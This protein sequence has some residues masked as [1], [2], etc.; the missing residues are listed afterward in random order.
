MA[1]SYRKSIRSKK[2]RK[3]RHQRKKTEKRIKKRGL[4]LKKNKRLRRSQILQYGGKSGLEEFEEL[5]FDKKEPVPDIPENQVIDTILVEGSLG[6]NESIDANEFISNH[7]DTFR[8]EF[9]RYLRTLKL[10]DEKQAAILKVFD[11]KIEKTSPKFKFENGRLY[12]ISKSGPKRA[13]KRFILTTPGL[14]GFYEGYDKSNTSQGSG[15]NEDNMNNDETSSDN[16]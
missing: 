9:G 6:F 10:T 14:I 3:T 12:Y 5:L 8:K 13:F 4:S 7:K 2:N 16:E 1:R 15:K 11:E